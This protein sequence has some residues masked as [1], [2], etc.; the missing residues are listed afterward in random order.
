MHGDGG[1]FGVDLYAEKTIT[2]KVY[3]DQTPSLANCGVDCV[4]GYPPVG[5]GRNHGSGV[6]F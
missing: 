6:L 1:A 4:P 2:G 5:S 3:L